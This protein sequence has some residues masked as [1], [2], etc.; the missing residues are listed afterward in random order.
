M[1]LLM[2]SKCE[3]IFG[4]LWK[5][6][7]LNIVIAILDF[8]L[9]LLVNYRTFPFARAKVVTLNH[10]SFVGSQL[11]FLI[12]YYL[13]RH[14]SSKYYNSISCCYISLLKA[15]AKRMET[16][17]CLL[18]IDSWKSVN[19][20]KSSKEK[21]KRTDTKNKAKKIKSNNHSR[22]N[23]EK[24]NIVISTLKKNVQHWGLKQNI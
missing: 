16:F 23:R 6:F 2:L 24:S 11:L 3:I 9:L 5:S 17:C 19:F 8:S 15:I 14:C 1:I 7:F 21:K 20:R 4:T 10:I 18:L 13:Y 12:A 22:S